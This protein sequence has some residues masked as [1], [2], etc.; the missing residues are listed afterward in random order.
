M[1]FKDLAEETLSC[2]EKGYYTFEG[3][4]ISIAHKQKESKEK[5]LFIVAHEAKLLP[6][7]YANTQPKKN[8]K[9]EVINASTVKVIWDLYKLNKSNIGV[10]NFASAK[11]PG[12]G[13]IN[14]AMA[15]EESLAYSS[16][17]YETQLLHNQYYEINRK[18]RSMM[19]THNAIY[20]PDVIFF[21]D[22]KFRLVES[23]I[24]ASVLTLPAVNMGQVKIKGESEAKAKEV[25]KERMEIALAILAHQ[26]EKHIILGAYG[27][28]VFRNN[29]EEVATWWHELLVDKNYKSLFEGVYFAILDTSKDK[30]CLNAFKM[31]I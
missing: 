5:S 9:M 29:P 19:Y 2:L 12:G 3:K 21:R 25:M 7:Q 27:C 6:N 18:N 23:P 30:K 14:G 1:K 22:E 28:G 8:V 24:T 16:N 31:M 26:G 4:T 11:N 15:Q 10:L 13:F 17:L 20:S